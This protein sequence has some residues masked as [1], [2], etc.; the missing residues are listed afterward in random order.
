MG[1]CFFCIIFVNE[2]KEHYMSI[3]TL[4]IE[5]QEFHNTFVRTTYEILSKLKFDYTIDE[6]DKM[7]VENG[8]TL[9]FH[10]R[11]TKKWHLGIWAVGEW[12]IKEEVNGHIISCG[13]GVEHYKPLTICVFLVHDWTYDKFKPSYADWYMLINENESVDECVNELRDIFKNPLKSYYRIVDAD[14][15]SF[16]HKNKNRFIAYVKGWFHNDFLHFTK[17]KRQRILGYLSTKLLMLITYFDKA[18]YLRKYKFHEDEW[19]HEYDIAIVFNYGET[20][21]DDWKRWHD[22]YRLQEILWKIC[23]YNI[24]IEFTYVDEEGKE[25]ENIWRG[26]YWEEEPKR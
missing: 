4:K 21:W 26:V 5:N 7:S 16:Q 19:N 6:V 8:Y 23:D 11:K 1:V 17:R 14:S 15:Y 13:Y 25:P 18:V 10:N 22:Y 2:L 9:H 24:W 20:E 3:K 12:E